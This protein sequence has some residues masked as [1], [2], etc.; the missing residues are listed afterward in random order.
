MKDRRSV[1]ALDYIQETLDLYSLALKNS[2]SNDAAHNEVR[3]A[4]DV[5]TQYFHACAGSPHNQPAQSRFLKLPD[6]PPAIEVE[7]F[8]SQ[9]RSPYAS[10]VRE[11]S[12]VSYE[13]FLALNL[14]RRSVRWF[15]QRSVEPEKLDMMVNAARLAPSAC[16]R[17]PYHFFIVA[18]AERAQIGAKLAGGTGGFA[19]QIPALIVVLGD[20]SCYSE[21]KDRHLI[22]IDS[23]LASMSLML[24]AETVGL[25]TC[26]IN[27]SDVPKREAAM[28]KFL[29]TVP[30]HWRPIMLIAVG[31]AEDDGNVPFSSKKNMD[32]IRSL[33]HAGL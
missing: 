11:P 24:A 27:W 33:E 10:S 14:R 29:R 23:S 28:Y 13:E 1:F 12:P 3:W 26:P 20:L 17:Q 25:S 15:E 7:A 31:Y 4:Y 5:L 2:A 19:S 16:N 9:M 8:P 21:E 18:E 22:Y 32:I 6:P 30:E